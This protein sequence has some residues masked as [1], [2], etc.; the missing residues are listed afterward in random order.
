MISRPGQDQPRVVKKSPIL[1]AALAVL[2]ISLACSSTIPFSN[3]QARVPS[4]ETPLS[5]IAYVGN[6]GNIYTTGPNGKQ[7]SAV[8]RD[9]NLNPAAGQAGRFYQ[10]PTWAP[11][12]QRLAFVRFSS[13]QSGP[14]VSL[15]SALSDGKNAVN[16]FTS[17]NFQ[18]F[19][20]SWSPNSQYIAFLGSEASGALAQYLVAASGGE[21]KLI[22]SGQPY[23][24]DWSPDSHTLIVHIG[25]ASSANPNAR[26]AF[27]GLEGPNPK[28]ELDLKPASFEAPAWSPA[29]DV[30][31]LATQN[32]EGDDELVLAGQDGKVKQV[33][34]GLSGPVAF[35][36]SPKGVYLAYPVLDLAGSVPTIHLVLLDSAHPNLHNQVSQ[37]ELVAFFWSPDGQKIAYFTLE[38]GEPSAT[39]FQT[40]AQTKRSASL[41]VQVYDRLSGKTNVVA[42]FVPTVSF[43]QIL[44]FYSQYQRSVTVWSP[45]SQNLVLS[46]I[47]EA[48]ENAIYTVGAD[49][50]QFQKIADGDL[51]FWS[52]K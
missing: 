42:T 40:V 28:Q 23:Y 30:L 11:D 9:A 27:I 49:G 34:A 43:Q 35:A 29:G 21:S 32:D 37:G 7:P 17:Q 50:S 25:G 13:S 24:W 44:P 14:E 12:G 36:W 33:L 22:S 45:D 31:A 15:F 52:W 48:G 10:Y 41:V 3:S 46:G 18:P 19:Y 6:D 38:S 51:A 8:T 2:A 47:D 26:L 1:K 5:L 4:P 39:S 20:L 16:I